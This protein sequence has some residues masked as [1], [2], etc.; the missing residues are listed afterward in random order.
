M[1]AATRSIRPSC[2]GF[3]P[4]TGE[5]TGNRLREDTPVANGGLLDDVEVWRALATEREETIRDLRHRLDES[6]ME[7]RQVQE[8]L[9][10][11]LTHRQVGS[12]PLV[13]RTETIISDRRSWWRR[14][15]R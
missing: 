8:R 10:G 1:T 5:N 9:T 11:L 14:W 2:T 6:E 12:V 3:T 4:L 15:F 13:Q 7:R